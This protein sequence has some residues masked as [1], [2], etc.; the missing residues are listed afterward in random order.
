MS[1]R[2]REGRAWMLAALLSIG[3]VSLLTGC[4]GDDGQDEK[5]NPPAADKAPVQPPQPA[6]QPQTQPQT[7]PQPETQPQPQ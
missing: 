3:G 5:P 4:G 1:K 6:S 7:Q 2:N